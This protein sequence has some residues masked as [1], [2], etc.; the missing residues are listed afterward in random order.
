M[1]SLESFHFTLGDGA[2]QLSS[3]GTSEQPAAHPDPPVNPPAIDCHACF[4][5]RPLPGEDVGVDRIDEGAV[6]IEDQRGHATSQNVSPDNVAP[7]PCTLCRDGTTQWGDG[8]TAT[9][10]VTRY[11]SDS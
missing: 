8:A 11:H 7:S 4:G 2:A 5:Q 3:N 10:Y 1:S 9:N 6:E